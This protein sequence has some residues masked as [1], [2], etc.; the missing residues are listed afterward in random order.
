MLGVHERNKKEYIYQSF[1][2]IS[3]KRVTPRSPA[4]KSFLHFRSSSAIR[5]WSRQQNENPKLWAAFSLCCNVG[6]PQVLNLANKAGAECIRCCFWWET[7]KSINF[8]EEFNLRYGSQWKSSMHNTT[9]QWQTFVTDLPDLLSTDILFYQDKN[10]YPSDGNN[11]NN[12]HFT[13][14]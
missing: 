10:K 13:L 6:S 14:L 8:S 7:H 3:F 5:S 1:N 11:G 9:F 4:W 12:E 2:I